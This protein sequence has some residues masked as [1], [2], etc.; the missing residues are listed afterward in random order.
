MLWLKDGVFLMCITSTKCVLPNSAQ[1]LHLWEST[2]LGSKN[3]ISVWHAVL[4]GYYFELFMRT[5][6]VRKR[7]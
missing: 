3:L 5:I 1:F 4:M 7:C 2:V 6:R